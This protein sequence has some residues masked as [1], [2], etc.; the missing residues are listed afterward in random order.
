M[1]IIYTTFPSKEKAEQA[2][3]TLVKEKLVACAN[4]FHSTSI[5]TW[6]EKLEKTDE[7]AVLL[8][9]KSSLK[10]SV[11]SRLKELHPYKICCI[12][13]I[14]VESGNEEYLKWVNE[15]TQ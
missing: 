4:I 1:Y 12:L 5:F 15:S 14:P 7:W 3:K 13:R 2:S 9:T 8:K 11:T 10:N 6:K